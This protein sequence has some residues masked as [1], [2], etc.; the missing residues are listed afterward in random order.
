MPVGKSPILLLTPAPSSFSLWV[1]T[2]GFGD[3]SRAPP[4]ESA[5]RIFVTRHG[6]NGVHEHFKYLKEK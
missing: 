3:R 4:S 1:G 6:F 5:K 2:K